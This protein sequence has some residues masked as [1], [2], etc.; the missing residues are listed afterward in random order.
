MAKRTEMQWEVMFSDEA[1]SEI[2]EVKEGLPVAAV[3]RKQRALAYSSLL[4]AG[5][6]CVY[7]S[8]SDKYH[9][10]LQSRHRGIGGCHNRRATEVPAFST[11]QSPKAPLEFWEE[12]F[13]QEEVE[14]RPFTKTPLDYW[15]DKF[16]E[17][18]VGM[19]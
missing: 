15:Q 14:G 1:W 3:P 7:R 17:Q 16:L 6:V 19:R 10:A 13:F 18:E 5:L 12:K 11:I 2:V 9:P 4:M 8:G